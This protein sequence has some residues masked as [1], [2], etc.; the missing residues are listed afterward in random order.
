[1]DELKEK[2]KIILDGVIV[3]FLPALPHPKYLD[4]VRGLQEKRDKAVDEV[5]SVVNHA[6]KRAKMDGHGDGITESVEAVVK[7]H[8]E[9]HEMREILA[10]LDLSVKWEL[11]PMIKARIKEVLNRG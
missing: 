8:R 4:Y 3:G 10:A 7:A 2:I 6:I 11:A 1:M 5:M 9:T